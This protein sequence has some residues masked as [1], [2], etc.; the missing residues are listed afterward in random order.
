MTDKLEQRR[1]RRTKGVWYFMA[2]CG[3]WGAPCGLLSALL[4]AAAMAVFKATMP[5]IL[6]LIA[7]S[8]FAFTLGGLLWGYAMWT[9]FE[10]S[11]HEE[12]CRRLGQKGGA[13]ARDE[14]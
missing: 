14:P 5:A 1:Q 6:P 13:V 7:C 11:Y 2:I 9:I 12:T 4:F 3:A 10:K 8:M